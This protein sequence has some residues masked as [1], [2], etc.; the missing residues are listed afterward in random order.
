MTRMICIATL[1]AVVSLGLVRGAIAADTDV[2]A[3]GDLSAFKSSA[4]A[5]LKA[6][7]DDDMKEAKAK[8]K[9]LESAWDASEGTLK[10]KAAAP[11]SVV[12]KL[13]DKAL[14]AVRAD[15]TDST[16]CKDAIQAVIDI[17]TPSKK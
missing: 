17:C 13:I 12:D 11:W 8:M 16:K 7:N 14:F 1:A 6:V 9:E 3:L 2:S 4:D 10:K 15:K 5:A